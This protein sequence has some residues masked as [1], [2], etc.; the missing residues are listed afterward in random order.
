MP[1]RIYD[2]AKKLGIESKDVLAEAKKLGIAAAKVPSSSLDKITAGFLEETLVKLYPPP[3]SMAPPAPPAPAEP[4]L[5]P[6][7]A[8]VIVTEPPAEPQPA[9]TPTGTITLPETPIPD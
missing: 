9:T 1:V 5:A 2:L 6:P 8:I 4:V 7:P 3:V